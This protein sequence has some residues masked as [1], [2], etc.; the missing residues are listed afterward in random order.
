MKVPVNWLTRP[1]RTQ[2]NAKNFQN[3]AV[4]SHEMNLIAHQ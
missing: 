3:F 2:T 4:S 1:T